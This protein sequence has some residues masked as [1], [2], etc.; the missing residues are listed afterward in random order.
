MV[1]DFRSSLGSK[2]YKMFFLEFKYFYIA[3]YWWLDFLANMINEGYLGLIQVA[4]LNAANPSI[5]FNSK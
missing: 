5:R 4:R 3:Y 1:H 2:Q